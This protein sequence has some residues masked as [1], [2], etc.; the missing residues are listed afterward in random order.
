MGVCQHQVFET[1][2]VGGI[3]SGFQ[4]LE[5]ETISKLLEIS[6]IITVFEFNILMCQLM[7]ICERHNSL[8]AFL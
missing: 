2:S 4:C 5:T 7:S 1:V 6:I 3:V 8:V